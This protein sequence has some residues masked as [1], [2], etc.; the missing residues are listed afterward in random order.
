MQPQYLARRSSLMTQFDAAMSQRSATCQSFYVFSRCSDT[1]YG[2]PQVVRKKKKAGREGAEPRPIQLGRYRSIQ[3]QKA[4]RP[5]S[6]LVS[7]RLLPRVQIRATSKNMLSSNSQRFPL[8][9]SLPENTTNEHVA[10]V[11]QAPAL[12][13]RALL[14][15]EG[16]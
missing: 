11:S 15:A 7:S 14:N 9:R 4:S 3:C 8:S 2:E 12:D 16:A 5:S 13:P 6:G 10:R 1:L